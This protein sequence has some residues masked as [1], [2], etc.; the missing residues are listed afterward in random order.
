VLALASALLA[1]QLVVGADQFVHAGLLST[2]EI[3]TH[4][5]MISQE[6]LTKSSKLTEPAILR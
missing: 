1:V 3:V 6:F 2:D 5:A 4:D